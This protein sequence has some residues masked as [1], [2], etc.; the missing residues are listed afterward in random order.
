[1]DLSGILGPPSMSD[2]SHS[3]TILNRLVTWTDRGI[4][5]EADPRHVESSEATDRR[6]FPDAETRRWLSESL[7]TFGS[8]I[9]KPDAVYKS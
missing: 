4:E 8:F 6:T 7:S 1:M 5:L 9:S 3:I 2:V